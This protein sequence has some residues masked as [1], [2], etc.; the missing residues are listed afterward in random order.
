MYGDP[1][2]DKVWGGYGT[3]RIHTEGTEI[4]EGGERLG[5]EAVNA[6]K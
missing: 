3:R 5:L 4:T 6:F 2:F 1:R